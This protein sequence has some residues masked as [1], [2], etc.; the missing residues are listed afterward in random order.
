MI[1]L[2][3]PGIIFLKSRKTAGSSLEIALSAFAGEDD[4][5]TPIDFGGPDDTRRAELGYPGAQN[6]RKPVHGLFTRP[7]W[8]D[9]RYFLQGK[10]LRKHHDHSTAR[11]VRRHLPRMQWHRYSKISV[12]RNPWDYMVSSYYWAHRNRESLPS[13]QSWCLENNRLM[14]RN[15]RQ[16]FIGG[17]CVIDH[18]IRFEHLVKDLRNLEER[19][20]ALRG[21]ADIFSGMSAKKGVRPKTGP[22]LD[23]FYRDAPQVDQLIRKRCRFEVETFGYQAP[24]T[25][26]A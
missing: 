26:A 5:I 23:E 22:N 9:W 7:T 19:F 3:E 1:I 18:F 13:F 21:V 10:P 15:H 17:Q 11:R 2:H 6:Y 24:N 4:V 8:R 25:G 14:N 16:Y 12:V 20:P